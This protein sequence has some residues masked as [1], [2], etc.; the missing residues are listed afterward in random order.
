MRVIIAKNSEV[1]ITHTGSI[2]TWLNFEKAKMTLQQQR[3]CHDAK[4]IRI[5]RIFIGSHD[6][7]VNNDEIKKYIAVMK[8]MKKYSIDCYYLKIAN[9][10]EVIDMTWVPKLN[11]LSVWKP[12]IGGGVATIELTKDNVVSDLHTRWQSLLEDAKPYDHMI[13]T[14]PQVLSNAPP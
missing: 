12:G 8:E 7:D 14:S 13:S 1:R 11:V 10:I 9:P 4:N 6:Y 5:K 3:R 2:D